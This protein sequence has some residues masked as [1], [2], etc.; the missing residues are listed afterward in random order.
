MRL[1]SINI[2]S[3]SSLNKQLEGATSSS[4]LW[5][6][7]MVT[8]KN[9]DVIDL[10][11]LSDE[12]SVFFDKNGCPAEE[13]MSLRMINNKLTGWFRATNQATQSQNH[14]SQIFDFFSYPP[15]LPK[16][17]WGP[18]HSIHQVENVYSNKEWKE[19]FP[20]VTMPR[21]LRITENL[22]LFSDLQI[23]EARGVKFGTF[24]KLAASVE[25]VK[26][27]ID[28]MALAKET[29]LLFQDLGC[30][31]A[32]RPALK[33]ISDLLND[34]FITLEP[35]DQLFFVWKPGGPAVQAENLYTDEEW[36]RDFPGAEMPQPL[37]EF[38]VP[39]HKYKLFSDEQ[40]AA[41]RSAA[42]ELIE[43]KDL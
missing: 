10:Q 29:G 8:L 21:P 5:H 3:Y 12:V 9:S 35:S 28:L 33:S 7:R 42:Y 17:M 20:R 16:T 36:N 2:E 4:S 1:N 19:Q 38:P 31:A 32:E 13:R 24:S 30:L 43:K 15:N 22:N 34:W 40:I 37:K 25:E 6:G 14:I 23:L 39:R 11:I 27:T 26:G 18:G 41:A